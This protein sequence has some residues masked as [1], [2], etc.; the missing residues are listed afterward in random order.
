MPVASTPS[1]TR[2]NSKSACKSL[3]N[4]T[5]KCAREGH[6]A[7]ALSGPSFEREAGSTEHQGQCSKA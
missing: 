1:N 3:S 7:P 6:L 5:I 4:I 2:F